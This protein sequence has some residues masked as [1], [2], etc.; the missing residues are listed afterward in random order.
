[1]DG[2]K[3]CHQLPPHHK[4]CPLAVLSRQLAIAVKALET[5]EHD[6]IN[7]YGQFRYDVNFGYVSEALAKLRGNA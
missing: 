3:I 4:D 1:M 5:I 6:L 2:C 7:E